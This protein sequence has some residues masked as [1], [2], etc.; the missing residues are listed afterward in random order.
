MTEILSAI[1]LT[2]GGVVVLLAAVGVVRMPD[3]MTRMQT[4]SKAVTLGL[5]CLMLAVALHF[6]EIAALRAAA[7]VFFFFVTAPV[8]AHVI[9]RAAYFV[10]TKLWEGS[11]ID[12]LRGRYDEVTHRLRSSGHNQTKK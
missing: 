8:A 12:E 2:I 4:T 5:G 9:A 3:L 6:G 11:V 10:G 7:I 1:A